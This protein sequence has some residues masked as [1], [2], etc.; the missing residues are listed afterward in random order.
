M[1]QPI[2]L[3]DRFERMVQDVSRYA[4]PKGAVWNMQDW[5]P[6]GRLN[7]DLTK[8]GGWA[9]QGSALASLATGATY[10]D[11]VSH[12]NFTG[13]AQLVAFTDNGKSVK[14]LPSEAL[15][16][17]TSNNPRQTVL[18]DNRLIIPDNNGTTAPQKYDGTTQAA[19][20]G[21][22]PALQ[23]VCAYK[24]RLYGANTTANKERIWA[25]AVLDPEVW[26]TTN[27]Y[28]DATYP[29]TGL[30]SLPNAIMI[31]QADQTARV[32]GSVP[33]PGGDFVVDDPIFNVGCSDSRSIAT[34]ANYVFFAS[35][36]G[37]FMSSGTN[38][39]EDLT[40][41]CGMS[42][43]WKTQLASYAAS[44]WTLAGGIY[45]NLYWLTVM[46]GATFVDQF[47]FDFVSRSG[48]RN[49]NF[50]AVAF[51]HDQVASEEG[52]FALRSTDRVGKMSTMFTPSATYK[53]DGN[54]TAVTPTL[55]LSAAWDLRTGKKR[56]KNLYTR[57]KMTDAATDDP[58][59]TASQT[60]Q[61]G[62]SPTY[63]AL[64]PTLAETDAT[65]LEHTT[66][67]TP[68]RLAKDELA[69]KLAQTNASATTEIA[70]VL[71]DVHAREG[72]RV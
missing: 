24:S 36:A 6:G 28:L 5:I 62:T 12:A 22:P 71:V 33:P 31:F 38:F 18:F 50:S 58:I 10:C 47:V 41:S 49:K 27:G 65:T 4:L 64:S 72:G 59:L 54:S 25:S 26:D 13:G 21:S 32:R 9:Y 35:P 60:A 52:Y 42:Q 53:N 40:A 29:V 57:Y 17:A 69:F 11:F 1:A 2:V 7:A 30:A 68:I 39:P 51:A 3:Q 37:V 61:L 67:K 20:G 55:E 15:I 8:R 46:N 19:L 45:R 70:A 63:T 66:A 14:L 44:T 43:L 56:W 34:F 48:W 23:Y 16:S